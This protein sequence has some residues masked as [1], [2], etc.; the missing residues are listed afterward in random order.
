MKSCPLHRADFAQEAWVLRCM[1]WEE[2]GPHLPAWIDSAR[3]V[4]AMT[5]EAIRKEDESHARAAGRQR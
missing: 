1:G 3:A 4:V 2:A 5:R